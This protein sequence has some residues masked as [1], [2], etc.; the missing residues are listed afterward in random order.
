MAHNAIFQDKAFLGADGRLLNR[1]NQRRSLFKR[2]EAISAYLYASRSCSCRRRCFLR[3]ILLLI[4][5][6][7]GQVLF[8]REELALIRYRTL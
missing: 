4:W 8:A 2:H 6:L 3:L 5:I 7:E 1:V